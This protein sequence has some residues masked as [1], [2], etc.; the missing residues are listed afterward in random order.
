[1]QQ[2]A[3]RLC[4]G[5]VGVALGEHSADPLPVQ[6]REGPH[7]A[8]LQELEGID[9]VCL[10][11]EGLVLG[12]SAYAEVEHDEDHVDDGDRRL[13]EVVVVTGDELAQLVDEHPE[14]DAT[15]DCRYRPAERAERSQQDNDGHQHPQTAPEHVSD[16]ESSRGQRGV[17]GQCEKDPD[18]HDGRSGRDEEVLEE[19]VGKEITAERISTQT[20][21]ESHDSQLLSPVCSL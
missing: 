6:R 1:M 2:L 10:L 7:G 5:M 8:A 20:L 16:M 17:A 12:E 3:E 14:T 21:W 15:D 13:E 19:T 4:Q 18:R 11:R 9:E